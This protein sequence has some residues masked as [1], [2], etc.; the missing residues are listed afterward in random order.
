MIIS[1]KTR[2]KCIRRARKEVAFIKRWGRWFGTIE[3]VGGVGLCAL[4]TLFIGVMQRVAALLPGIG[5]GQAGQNAAQNN[6]VQNMMWG[7]LGL[8][9]VFGMIVGT[10]LLLGGIHVFIGIKRFRGDPASQ[11]LIE[12]H[13]ALVELSRGGVCALPDP[14]EIT[15][16]QPEI[17]ADGARD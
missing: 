16:S 7:G 6:A 17:S 5:Q 9:L 1:P 14:P 15:E 3:I 12:Y 8:G 10:I 13:D 4:G 11:I 2:E